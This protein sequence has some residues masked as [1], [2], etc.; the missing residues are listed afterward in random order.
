[1][2]KKELVRKT[3]GSQYKADEYIYSVVWSDDDEVFVGRVVEFPSLAAHGDTM[4][5]ALKEIRE[6]VGYVLKDLIESGETVPVPLNK[7]QFS[8][9]LNLRMPKHLHRQ[10]TAEA[11]REGVSLN[12]WINTKLAYQRLVCV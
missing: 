9:K 6:V 1:M 3:E 4:E 11:E 8:G 7:R 5:D 12:Q 10:L 2:R